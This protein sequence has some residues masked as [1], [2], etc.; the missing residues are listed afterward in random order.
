MDNSRKC[1]VQDTLLTIKNAVKSEQYLKALSKITEIEKRTLKNK[2][3]CLPYGED[4]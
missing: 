4:L 2:C 3:Y 1:G